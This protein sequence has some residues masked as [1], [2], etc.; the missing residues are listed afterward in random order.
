MKIYKFF[1]IILSSATIIVLLFEAYFLTQAQPAPQSGS[2]SVSVEKEKAGRCVTYMIQFAAVKQ[3]ELAIFINQQFRQTK[4]TADLIG[5]AIQHIR[6]Y[7]VEIKTEVDKFGPQPGQ[8]FNVSQEEK[9]ACEEWRQQDYEN[10]IALAKQHIAQT[11][12]AKKS[13]LLI[14]KYKEINSKLGTLN[15]TL[16]QLAA[17]L[18]TFAQ[19]LSCFAT[20][21]SKG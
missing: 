10:V 3:Q 16:G 8:S 9:A 12:S 14:A 17:Y 7:R 21:C 20:R 6:Q 13:L 11:S 15:S 1:N 4:P 18:G 5:E 19:Q 2:P